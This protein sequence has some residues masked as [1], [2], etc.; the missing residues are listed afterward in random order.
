MNRGLSQTSKEGCEVRD[1]GMGVPVM[2]MG[3]TMLVPLFRY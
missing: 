2:A 1:T 3:A